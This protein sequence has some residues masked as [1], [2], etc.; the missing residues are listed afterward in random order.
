MWD[1]MGGNAIPATT[2]NTIRKREIERKRERERHENSRRQ[3]RQSSGNV[4]V[5]DVSIQADAQ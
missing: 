2:R 5:V 1:Y 4:E 3:V